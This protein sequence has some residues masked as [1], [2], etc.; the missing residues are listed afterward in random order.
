M[1]DGESRFWSG[2]YGISSDNGIPHVRLGIGNAR[3]N[4]MSV[5]NG[6]SVGV[7]GDGGNESTSGGGAVDE[8]RL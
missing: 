4:R 3:E 6:L 8:A 5:R 1:K 2:A 7:G